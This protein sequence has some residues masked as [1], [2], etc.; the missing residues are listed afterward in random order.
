MSESTDD[1]Q[2]SDADE[3]VSADD[4]DAA[5]D[6]EVTE[7][8]EPEDDSIKLIIDGVERRVDPGGLVIDACN[9]HGSYVPHFCYHPRMSPVGMC[10]Q[11]LVEVE[12]LGGHQ[13]QA[14]RDGHREALDQ[15]VLAVVERRHRN[16]AQRPTRHEDQRVEGLLFQ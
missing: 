14:R 4:V 5:V 6:E 1:T 8:P 16:R 11:C 7:E 2:A 13:V 9:E 10:R 3:D 15:E 12:G